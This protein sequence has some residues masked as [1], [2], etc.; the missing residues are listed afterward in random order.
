MRAPMIRSREVDHIFSEDEHLFRVPF[1][2]TSSVNLQ[3]SVFRVTWFSR[4]VF[5]WYGQEG[6]PVR[7]AFAL[8]ARCRRRFTEDIVKEVRTKRGIWSEP[9]SSM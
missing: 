3:I 6:D 5:L 2:M 7:A 8:D 4:A 9:I 1:E